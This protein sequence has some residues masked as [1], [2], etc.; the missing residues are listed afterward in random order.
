[1]TSLFPSH[2]QSNQQVLQTI[3][4]IQPLL[5]TSTNT[6]RYGLATIFLLPGRD[7]ERKQVQLQIYAE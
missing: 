4:K 2:S 5:T 1:M 3:V 6:I 7:E